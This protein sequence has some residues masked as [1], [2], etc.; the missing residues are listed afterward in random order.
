[1][2]NKITTTD[3]MRA[4]LREAYANV[5]GEE[6]SVHFTLSRTE[7]LVMVQMDLEDALKAM[8]ASM[9]VI[10]ARRSVVAAL[11]GVKALRDDGSNEDEASA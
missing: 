4:M 3:A 2:R 7:M 6:Q 1:M 11:N 5:H 10:R 8:G 9:R